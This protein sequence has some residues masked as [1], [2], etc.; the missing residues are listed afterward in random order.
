M[1]NTI[2]IK[3]EAPQLIINMFN[4]IVEHGVC[5]DFSSIEISK[6]ADSFRIKNNLSSSK[7]NYKIIT[8]FSFYEKEN[9]ELKKNQA[10]SNLVFE[11][12]M[13]L[14]S[15]KSEL[16][17]ILFPDTDIK[18]ENTKSNIKYNLTPPLEAYEPVG[19][20]Q[21]DISPSGRSYGLLFE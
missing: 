14:S 5:E 7:K 8:D 12:M 13:I 4:Y 1:K 16:L 2:N 19:N 11:L 21:L 20:N 10:D 15:F 9:Y 17:R 18:I 3:K 6:V